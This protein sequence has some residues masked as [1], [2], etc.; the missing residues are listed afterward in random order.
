MTLQ[1]SLHA[2]ERVWW[3]IEIK[4]IPLAILPR[5]WLLMH[6]GNVCFHTQKQA[7]RQASK[8]LTHSVSWVSVKVKFIFTRHFFHSFYLSC[9]KCHW[10]V[11]ASMTYLPCTMASYAHRQSVYFECVAVSHYGYF[12]IL[13]SL[14]SLRFSFT[15]LN[16]TVALVSSCCYCFSASYLFDPQQMSNNW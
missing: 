8:S 6:R 1:L 2:C 9:D 15:Q 5:H 12:C 3:V 11:T 7:G 14:S 13:F 10:Q 4:S 16:I